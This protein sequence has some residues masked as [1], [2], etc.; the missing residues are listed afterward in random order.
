MY[1]T[2]SMRLTDELYDLLEEHHA[3]QAQQPVSPQQQQQ[4]QQRD[5]PS[6]SASHQFLQH[7]DT[8]QESTTTGIV[9]LQASLKALRARKPSVRAA[10]GRRTLRT[11]RGG[12]ADTADGGGLGAPTPTGKQGARLFGTQ[13]CRT[14]VGY[15]RLV[16]ARGV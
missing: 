5:P 15:R 6:H 2:R 1:G 16:R 9:A 10:K 3:A 12:G 7:Q 8:A 11:G 4:Q 14:R 13:V